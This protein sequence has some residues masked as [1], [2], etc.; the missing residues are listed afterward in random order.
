MSEYSFVGR[1]TPLREGPQKVTGAIRYL[2]DMRLPGML[3]ARLVPSLY[4]HARING[5]DAQAARAV[6]GVVA[7]FTARDLPDI[8]P[9]SRSRLL[10]ARDRALFVGH[11]VALVVAENEAAA[12]DGAGLVAVDY[13]PLPAAVT[14]E[15]ALAEGAPL[16]WPEGVPGSAGDAAAHGADASGG[17]ADDSQPSNLV[18]RVHYSRGDVAA[19]FAEA[20]AIIERTYSTP[21]VHQNYIEPQ[22]CIVAPDLATGEFTLWSS[23]QAPFGARKNVAEVLD[24]PESTVKVI[25]TPVGGGFGA[26]WALYD[27]LI[28]L[29]A[30]KLGRPVRLVLT[31]QEDLLATNPSQAIQIRAR[32]GLKRDGTIAALEGS[33]VMDSGCYAFSALGLAANLF[34]SLYRIAN[35]DITG[36]E[37][38]TFKPSAGA[39]RAPTAPTAAFAIESAIDEAASLLGLDPLEVRLKNAAVS[40]D[41]RVT[42]QPWANLGMVQ[43]L[44]RLR[45]HPA[46]QGRQAARAAGRG[47]GVAIGGW[48]GGTEPAAAACALDRD[49]T[50]RVQIGATDLTGTATTFALLAAEAFGIA[51][52]SV[53]IVQGDTSTAPYAGAAGGSKTVYTVGPALIQ[54]AREAR[55]NALSIAA[56]EF[57]ADPADLE[58]V[59]GKVRVRGVPERTI[60]LADVAGKAMDFGSKYLPVT[61][62]GRHADTVQSPGFCAQLAEVEV[63][64]ETGDVRVHR[65]VMVQDV[66]QAINPLAVE[67]QMMGGGMQGLGWALYEGLMY[68]RQGQPLNGSWLEYAVPH[69]AHSASQV[70][71]V[72]VEVPTDHGPLGAR[73]VGEPPVIATA[74]A[75]ANA[76]ADATGARMGQLP[77][78]P[79]RLV[80]EL[81][82]ANGGASRQAN[83]GDAEPG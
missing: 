69:V 3:H 74:A 36:L 39:Y 8:E 62:H 67:G 4:A 80:A 58:I 63:D 22:A 28:A 59:D 16:V 31:R 20:D 60:S 71:T 34:G 17:A 61:G 64:R 82:N 79:Q 52:E 1:R 73:G 43:V 53:R 44:E 41:P 40:G 48:P 49:G 77:I 46:W 56:D 78:T 38:L 83:L 55:A 14:P 11:P 76:I 15:D 24:V 35:L 70:E 25:G 47:V 54:A 68:D 37:V 29:A 10:L 57:E 21:V 2:P 13:E 42:G 7:V 81:S 12:Q 50:L 30:R 18:E 26:K 23:T 9:S 27:P 6:P 33:I 72:I 75:V 19:G 32:L 51:P 65:L 66:G 5:I 45:D